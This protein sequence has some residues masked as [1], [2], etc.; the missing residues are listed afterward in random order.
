V[1]SAVDDVGFTKPVTLA[2]G[3]TKVLTRTGKLDDWAYQH[4]QA[5]IHW[6]FAPDGAVA[7]VPGTTSSIVLTATV[8]GATGD[9]LGTVCVGSQFEV[10]MCEYVSPGGPAKGVP[11]VQ[12][13]LLDPAND[14]KVI[15]QTTTGADGSFAFR[16]VPAGQRSLAFSAPTGWHIA[17]GRRRDLSR[18]AKVNTGNTKLLVGARRDTDRLASINTR[19]DDAA[20]AAS[21]AA[22]GP[23]TPAYDP[24]TGRRR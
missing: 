2:V 7:S 6:T 19:A 23:A 22:V 5:S 14:T 9:L 20:V 15:A 4:G 12:V 21:K 13:S 16:G 11:G 8:P 10:L 3:E 18:V 1:W 17:G 24:V